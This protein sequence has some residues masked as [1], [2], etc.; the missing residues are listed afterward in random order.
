MR[1]RIVLAGWTGLLGGTGSRQAGA[2]A[3]VRVGQLVGGPSGRASPLLQ[4]LENG[5]VAAGLIPGRDFA[6]QTRFAA[7]DALAMGEVI[8]TWLPEIDL[9]VAWGT[10]GGMAAKASA[11]SIP[12]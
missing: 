11:P 10:I 3:L 9:L 7:P 5:L 2:R 1:R 6:V 8:R 4:E 12:V